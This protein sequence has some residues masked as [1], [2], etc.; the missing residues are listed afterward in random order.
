MSNVSPSSAH[1]RWPGIPEPLL[2]ALRRGGCSDSEIAQTEIV[3]FD[4]PSDPTRI[5]GHSN[6]VAYL[7]GGSRALHMNSGGEVDWF[8]AGSLDPEATSRTRPVWR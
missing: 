4:R 7:P 1:Q 8:D 3:G 6:W 2:D 5:H